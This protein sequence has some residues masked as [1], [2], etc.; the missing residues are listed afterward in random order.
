MIKKPSFLTMLGV[1]LALAIGPVSAQSVKES[2]QV[3]ARQQEKMLYPP[4]S[5][6]VGNMSP[7]MGRAEL[8]RIKPFT[9]D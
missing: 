9:G 5:K 6:G 2:D 7:Q 3:G 1:I 4:L 8:Q